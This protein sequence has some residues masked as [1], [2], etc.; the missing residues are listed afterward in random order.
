MEDPI[1]D[2]D[3]EGPDPDKKDIDEVKDKE[4]LELESCMEVLTKL[5][6]DLAYSSEKLVNLHG[7]SMH[8]S[9]QENELEAMAMGNNYTSTEFVEKTLVFDLL[10]GVLESEVRELDSF[11]VS[12]QA[13]IVDAH[14]K[15]S[16]CRHL[17]EPYTMMEEKLRDSEESLKQTQHRISEVKIQSTKL[18]RT[19]LAFAHDN[20]KLQ[21][22][23]SHKGVY[24]NS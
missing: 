20:C 14:Q 12:L 15:I 1:T 10:S 3:I 19:V 23:L 13:E 6:L 24:F 9:A 18:Q 2:I 5:D 16:S 11:M 7:L 4:T 17:T 22:Y 8:L 21:T